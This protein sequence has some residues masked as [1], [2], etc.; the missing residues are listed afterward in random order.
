MLMFVA[1][2]G[3]SRAIASF[4]TPRTVESKPCARRS[5]RCG[6]DVDRAVRRNSAGSTS[7]AVS[8]SAITT[9]MLQDQPALLVQRRTT[10]VPQ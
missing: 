6:S 3:L 10:V 2:L 4:A 1:E 8:G 5:W 9:G 7:D